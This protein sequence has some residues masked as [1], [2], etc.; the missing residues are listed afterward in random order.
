MRIFPQKRVRVGE[1]HRE[2]WHMRM[3]TNPFRRARLEGS[4]THGASDIRNSNQWDPE[5]PSIHNEVVHAISVSHTLRRRAVHNAGITVDTHRSH[6]RKGRDNFPGFAGAIAPRDSSSAIH[7]TR[8][9]N[10]PHLGQSWIELAVVDIVVIAIREPE[11]IRAILVIR[12]SGVTEATA[13]GDPHES[14]RTEPPPAGT[15]RVALRDAFSVVHK[16][17]AA[18]N[19]A[20]DT[21]SED[22]AEASTHANLRETNCQRHDWNPRYS[23]TRRTRKGTEVHLVRCT[24]TP[25]LYQTW[26][27]RRA[28]E[29]YAQTHTHT[30]MSGQY[31]SA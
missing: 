27:R 3:R 11:D 31:V 26:T 25:H 29:I 7:E 19:D 16:S 28:S 9:A 20:D 2:T 17:A 14:L 13:D 8:G 22:I 15:V 18:P 10:T 1:C 24:D 6:R 30:H 12:A 5:T 21:Q 4:D 23:G